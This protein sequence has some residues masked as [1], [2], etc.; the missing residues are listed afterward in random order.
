MSRTHVVYIKHVD[1]DPFTGRHTAFQCLPLCL[2]CIAYTHKEFPGMLESTFL[3]R[4]FGD[5]GVRL[6]TRK[7]SR[8]MLYVSRLCTVKATLT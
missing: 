7:E 6:K 3:A 8:T 5:Q 2:F 1:S 4:S